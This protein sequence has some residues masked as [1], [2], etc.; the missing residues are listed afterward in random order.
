[1]QLLFEKSEENE[2][3]P[4]LGILQGS[5]KRFSGNLKVP[6]LGWNILKQVKTS[7][8]FANVPQESYF[9]FAHSYY[10]Q[11]TDHQVVIGQSDYGEFYPVAIQQRNLFGV[12]FHPEKSQKYGLEILKNFLNL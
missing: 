12:Q 8:L 1:M 3:V 4:G 2:G 6:H 7:P 5:V 10:V 9:Y 11:P